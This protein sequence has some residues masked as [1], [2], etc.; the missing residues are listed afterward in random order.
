MFVWK[1]NFSSRNYITVLLRSDWDFFVF[2]SF[3]NN[4]F[5]F[6]AQQAKD[7]VEDTAEYAKDKA[8]DAAHYAKDKAGNA[9]D[10]GMR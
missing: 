4:I 10:Y 8:G 2:F 9:V 7:K 6:A 1:L 5:F 3:S